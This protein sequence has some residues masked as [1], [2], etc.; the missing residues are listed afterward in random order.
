MPSE[1]ELLYN[2]LMLYGGGDS[3]FQ[4]GA[5]GDPVI[6]LNLERGK[7]NIWLYIDEDF[8]K[9]YCEGDEEEAQYIMYSLENLDDYCNLSIIKSLINEIDDYPKFLLGIPNY[10]TAMEARIS[11][12]NKIFACWDLKEVF[13]ELN[14]AEL[15]IHFESC[16]DF[17]DP[18]N[19][20]LPY[21][22]KIVKAQ[23]L[24][25]TKEELIEAWKRTN[26]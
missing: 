2:Y 6:L 19:K 9:E 12:E 7:Y 8:L 24:H 10:Y 3:D 11:G 22:E 15:D 14:L 20:Y 5:L 1:S 26:G 25:P 13:N 21:L 4:L 18:N 23:D 16:K 17:K